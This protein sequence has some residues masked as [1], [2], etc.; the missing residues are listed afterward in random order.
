VPVCVTARSGER[1]TVRLTLSRAVVR[2]R[3]EAVSPGSCAAPARSLAVELRRLAS[4]DVGVTKTAT[5]APLT[6]GAVVQYT[7]VAHNFGPDLAATSTIQDTFT[8]SGGGTVVLG[9]IAGSGSSCGSPTAPPDP[10]FQCLIPQ[11][12][13]GGSATITIDA[14]CSTTQQPFVLTNTATLA[15]RGG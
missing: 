3:R 7:I 13:S 2:L 10:G 8:S 1:R 15:A 9:T 6:G 14:T 4:A 12:P 11:L 5:V